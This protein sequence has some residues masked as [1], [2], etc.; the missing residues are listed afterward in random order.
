MARCCWALHRDQPTV[1]IVLTLAVTG[2]PLPRRL[3]ADTGAGARASPFQLVLDEDDCLQCGGTPLNPIRLGGA[4][5][6]TFPLYAVRIMLPALGVDE[7][8]SVVAVPS[9]PTGFDGIAGFAFLNRFNYGNFG[10]A[11]LLGLEC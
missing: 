11:G 7:E 4:Y 1:E 9:T 10:D 3:L 8:L 2:Q 6:G 5:S